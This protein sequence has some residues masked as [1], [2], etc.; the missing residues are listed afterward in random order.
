MVVSCEV[1]EELGSL[2]SA[3][4]FEAPDSDCYRTL[5]CGVESGYR[6]HD[7]CPAACVMALEM[8]AALLELSVSVRCDACESVVE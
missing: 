8:P 4:E 7:A 6:Y 3:A 2:G 1:I 5:I